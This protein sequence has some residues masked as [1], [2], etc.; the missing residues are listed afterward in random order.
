MSAKKLWLVKEAVGI[1][2][3]DETPVAVFDSFWDA[4]DYVGEHPEQSLYI[5]EGTSNLPSSN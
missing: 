1:V 2:I 3:G 4:S 5:E